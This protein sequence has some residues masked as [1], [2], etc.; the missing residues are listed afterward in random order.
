MF[1]IKAYRDVP[2]STNNKP[3]DGTAKPQ[4]TQSRDSARYNQRDL[5]TNRV[6]TFISVDER[7]LAS[8][9]NL[10]NDPVYGP[11]LRQ[12]P[13][14]LT[15]EGKC[16]L[17]AIKIPAWLRC[18]ACQLFFVQPFCLPCCNSIICKRCMRTLRRNLYSSPDCL[19][20]SGRR[21][22]DPTIPC[23]S[24]QE[25]LHGTQIDVW[26]NP[27]GQLTLQVTIR[28]YMIGAHELIVRTKERIAVI[29]EE[30][31]DKEK[32]RFPPIT[33]I[34]GFLDE[35][36]DL[37]VSPRHPNICLTTELKM[38]ETPGS[39]QTSYVDI[40]TVTQLDSPSQPEE[41]CWRT[42]PVI[43][44][45]ESPH[46]RPIISHRNMATTRRCELI[47]LNSS[48]KRTYVD[49]GL[50][51]P[52]SKRLCIDTETEISPL[53]LGVTPDTALGPWKTSPFASIHSDD[54]SADED[55]SFGPDILS[56]DHPFSIQNQ[57]RMSTEFAPLWLS[58][59][60][61]DAKEEVTA[62]D[63]QVQNTK[64]GEEEV[65]LLEEGEDSITGM[66]HDFDF[67]TVSSED[68]PGDEN[69]DIGTAFFERE[70]AD[71]SEEAEKNA[72]Y[73]LL[74][75]KANAHPYF[76]PRK[77]SKQVSITPEKQTTSE[78]GLLT[79]P[80]STSST[81]DELQEYPSPTPSWDSMSSAPSSPIPTLKLNTRRSIAPNKKT[82]PSH[83]P[84]NHSRHIKAPL[85]T[86]TQTDHSSYLNQDQPNK[87]AN[88]TPFNLNEQLNAQKIYTRTL[89]IQRH[90][91]NISKNPSPI[92]PLPDR[93]HPK[94]TST[95]PTQNMPNNSQQSNPSPPLENISHQS[96]NT[97]IKVSKNYK[98]NLSARTRESLKLGLKRISLGV[99]Q[100]HTIPRLQREPKQPLWRY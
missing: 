9:P 86:P 83:I 97:N 94:K 81:Q 80:D 58:Y 50:E 52:S 49:I 28:H 21:V 8:L 41:I 5:V 13:D 6:K 79:P 64:L 100:N 25:P 11:F 90:M 85:T 99:L 42:M 60:Q 47:K 18:D 82:N 98:G 63:V 40:H 75:S 27:I 59:Y 32:A 65:E 51:D 1:F 38:K 95:P 45:G 72:R 55:T 68:E 89:D 29:A 73:N 34:A 78:F 3:V 62:P 61:V 53:Y 96:E 30:N 69:V 2:A 93:T 16:D 35:D 23:P 43:K 76:P 57:F 39:S 24:C 15:L 70:F 74:R 7:S 4:G 26:N 19:G 91:L 87:E 10:D 12:V 77:T 33:T 54:L 71:R 31:S 36:K 67:E 20:R 48:I 14:W 44:Y 92:P 84:N 56:D 17:S 46:E 37:N 22:P 88:E 66:L